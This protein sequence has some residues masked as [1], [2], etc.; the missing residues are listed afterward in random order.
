M[1]ESSW[2][3]VLNRIPEG[4]AV[5][6]WIG[7][8]WFEK[9]I[10]IDTNPLCNIACFHANAAGGVDVWIDMGSVQAISTKEKMIPPFS[11]VA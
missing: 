10:L 1:K 6:L 7:G 2:W 3:S 4:E 5:D 9:M 8:A 11:G